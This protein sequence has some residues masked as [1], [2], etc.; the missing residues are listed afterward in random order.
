MT[1]DALAGSLYAT[2]AVRGRGWSDVARLARAWLILV[3]ALA[4]V[5]PV[6]GRLFGLQ[7]VE[8]PAARALADARLAAAG[9]A[10][11]LR[12]DHT[13]EDL[14]LIGAASSLSRYLRAGEERAEDGEAVAADLQRFV[15]TN[16]WCLGVGVASTGRS[17]V[18]AER[19]DQ[20]LACDPLFAIVAQLT[21]GTLVLDRAEVAGAPRL[22]AGLSLAADVGSA[23]LVAEADPALLFPELA[24]SSAEGG[25]LFLADG[26]ERWLV[27]PSPEAT[28]V[29]R[30]LALSSWQGPAGGRWEIAR[31]LTPVLVPR[32]VAG[33]SRSES[34]AAIGLVAALMALALTSALDAR[35][36]LAR[37]P[38]SPP[39]QPPRP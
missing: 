35:R 27:G 5:L 26:H 17:A 39:P 12:L 2:H 15:A 10:T 30:P 28:L 14:L 3:T 9:H 33:P 31:V 1:S 24:A 36:R 8:Q 34:A 20:S 37:I 13:R 38:V 21:P 16:D 11:L 6:A 19:R 4:V 7:R 32:P 29:R 22:C 18:V 25:P 23:A